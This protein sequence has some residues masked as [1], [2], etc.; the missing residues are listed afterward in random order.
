MN[1]FG[2]KKKKY[3][4][5][6]Y[7]YKASTTNSDSYPSE[8]EIYHTE[9]KDQKDISSCVAHVS[10][11]IVEYFNHIQNTDNTKMSVGFIYGTRYND[12]SEGMYLRDALKT[13]KNLG[14]CSYDR[15]PYNEE[16]PSIINKVKESGLLQ[17]EYFPNRIS[18]YFS[19]NKKDI[20]AIKKCLLNNGP[21]M[22][23]VKWF[24]D[25]SV[26]DKKIVSNKKC[27]FGYHCIL[28]Y[29]WNKDG[30][31]ILNSWGKK[32]G[33]NGTAILPYDFG[34]EEVWG[35]IDNITLAKNIS[36]VNDIKISSKS[37]KLFNV[38]ITF[39]KDF[40]TI[41]FRK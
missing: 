11:E 23:S 14:D 28:I 24:E 33:N 34:L 36:F 15:F 38:F 8:F 9:V 2:A 1:T 6:D 16:V 27:D 40:I 39:I 18:S 5:R 32:W 41:L 26:K 21:V 37:S 35:V 10:A 12:E 20:N 17:D 22:V 29:G 30:W 7:K 13:L 19:I 25:I 4:P 3:D 31:K